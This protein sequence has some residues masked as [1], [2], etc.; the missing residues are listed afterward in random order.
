MMTLIPPPARYPTHEGTVECSQY[1]V[2]PAVLALHG[3]MGGHDQ[4]IILGRAIIPEG[5]RVVAPSRP[6]YLGTP[7]STGRSAAQQADALAA[8]L[9]MLDIDKTVVAAVSG[10]G[11]SAFHFALRHADRCRALILVSTCAG[12]LDT[13]VP[14]GFRLGMLLAHLPWVVAMT[15]RKALSNLDKAASRAIPDAALRRRTLSDPVAGPLYAALQASTFDRMVQRL[16]GSNNDL[17]VVRSTTYPL[18]EIKAPTL[19]VHGTADRLVPYEAHA[20]QSARRIPGAEL[21]SIEGGE[22]VSL[23]THRDPIAERVREFLNRYSPSP[24]KASSSSRSS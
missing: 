3:A 14:L 23:L 21:L 19:V 20:L 12:I 11:P 4:G 5:Y 17:A 13:P 10:G 2:G 8:L 18:E 6:G 15:R 22:H 1:G 24:S 7:L 9:D 16:E